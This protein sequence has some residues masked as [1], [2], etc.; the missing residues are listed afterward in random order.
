M[1][2]LKS[3]EDIVDGVIEYLVSSGIVSDKNQVQPGSILRTLIEAIAIEIYDTSKITIEIEKNSNITT[4]KGIYLDR[5][6][7]IHG[8]TRMP[9]ESDESFRI[10][11][12]YAI[13]KKGIAS[14]QNILNELYS[15]ENLG[16]VDIDDSASTPGSFIVFYRPDYPENKLKVR[17]AIIEKLQNI[18]PPGIKYIVKHPNIT[19][20]SFDIHIDGEYDKNTVISNIKNYV[21]NIKPGGTLYTS[22]IIGLI[23]SMPGIINCYI[24]NINI[25]DKNN[26]YANEIYLDRYD[27]FSVKEINLI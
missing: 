10:R 3:I 24:A 18:I 22:K 20:I 23:A 2:I 7:T 14:K 8:I 19:E 11:L 21:N 16:F 17:N 15:I 27:V 4:A 13:S 5:I 1:V 6:A 12:L 26:I 25:N 9:D